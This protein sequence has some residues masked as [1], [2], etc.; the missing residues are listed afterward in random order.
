[1]KP[2]FKVTADDKD[3]TDIFSPRLV[4]LN[5]TDETGL[6]SDKAEI[7]LDNRD[8]ILEIPPRGTNIEIS[9]GYENQDLVLMGSYIV[10]N[11]DLSSPPSRMRIVA[12]ASNTKIKDLTNKIRS[13]KSRSWHEYS[14]VGIVSKIAKE[15]KF[16]SL[17]DEYFEQI[18]IAHIDQTNE[19]DLS[20]L[21]NFARDY[22]AFI[23]FVAGK[24]IFAKKNKGATITG[25]EL[26]KLE[27]S[28][29]QITSWRLN[30]L[31]RDKFGKVI[32]KYHDFATA[33]EKKVTT[34]NG[35]PDYEMRYTFTDQNRA[36][37]AAKA[38][39]AEFE[40]GISKL[41]ISL[42]GNPILSAESKI[43]IPD[44]K[45]LKDRTWIVEAI[46]HD[47]SDQGYQSTIN[48]VEKF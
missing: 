4:S 7:L 38:K 39:L 30:I 31:D 15:H 44:I 27:L 5:I 16:I 36:L 22:D 48:A 2:I 25:K 13:P 43:I 23:K 26:P 29:N 28:E 17:I 20:F 21:T 11:I 46:T 42:P 9:L 32:A 3:I 19:S 40:R 47:I 33:E 18:Y 45:Y 35:E 6:V 37:E 8:N 14:L 34:G 41:E 1:M 24:L 12:K 10:D